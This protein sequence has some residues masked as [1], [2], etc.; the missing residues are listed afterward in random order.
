MIDNTRYELVVKTGRKA[1]VCH[2]IPLGDL[3][4]GTTL[5]SE[6]FIGCSDMWRQLL[7]ADSSADS[8]SASASGDALP[9]HLMRVTLTNHVQGLS[10]RVEQGFVEIG[11]QRL[12]PGDSCKVS[13]LDMIRIGA[14][15]MQIQPAAHT[16]HAHT[17]DPAESIVR[18]SNANPMLWPNWMDGRIAMSVLTIAAVVILSIGIVLKE[19]LAKEHPHQ[20]VADEQIGVIGDNR[21]VAV[22]SSSPAFLLTESGARFDV[23][24]VFEDGFRISQITAELVEFTRGSEIKNHLY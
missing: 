24:D 21:I 17:P 4:I 11:R 15:E 20:R 5:D 23:G 22:V 2:P 16:G 18:G 10:L 13:S 8:R 9:E 6:F 14:S 12:L 1:G 19:P 7:S 3:S